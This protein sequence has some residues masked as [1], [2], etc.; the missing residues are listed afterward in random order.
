MARDAPQSRIKYSAGRR[1][2]ELYYFIFI[3]VKYG[4]LGRCCLHLFPFLFGLLVSQKQNLQTVLHNGLYGGTGA[5][6]NAA[7]QA[8]CLAYGIDTGT[9][10]QQHR[11]CDQHCMGAFLLSQLHGFLLH[12]FVLV[13]EGA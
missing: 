4:W 7:A 5:G 13:E 3:W 2:P 8:V 11:F 9:G 10:L 1:R 12:F 6:N